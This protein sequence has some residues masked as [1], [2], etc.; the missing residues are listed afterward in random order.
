[1]LKLSSPEK[2]G[3]CLL[4]GGGLLNRGGGLNRGFTVSGRLVIQSLG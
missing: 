1:M 3:G 4:E 2:G